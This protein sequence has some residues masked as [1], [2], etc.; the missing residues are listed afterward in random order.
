MSMLIY[1]SR[2]CDFGFGIDDFLSLFLPD[3]DANI[4]CKIA[5]SKFAQWIG[6]FC[7]KAAVSGAKFRI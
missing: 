3:S 2:F 1:V 5:L 4:A 7:S 6:L